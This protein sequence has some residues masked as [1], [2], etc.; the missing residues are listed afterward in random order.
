MPA[1]GAVEEERERLV[2]VAGRLFVQLGYD[3][4]TMQMIAGAAGTSVHQAGLLVGSKQQ[5]YLEVMNRFTR[6]EAEHMRAAAELA[7]PDV[8]GLRMLADSYLDFSVEH[9][10]LRALWVHRWL[11]D[12]ADVENVEDLYKPLVDSVVEMFK[13]KLREDYDLQLGVWNIIWIVNGFIH[14]GIVDEKGRRRF[15]D[16]PPTLRRF[17]AYM[18]DVIERMAV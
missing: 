9:P 3:A 11:M 18:H 2:E 7:T 6:A 1:Q 16:H 8:V 17:R 12:A 13:D 15:A 4:T 14:V 5:L 10:E